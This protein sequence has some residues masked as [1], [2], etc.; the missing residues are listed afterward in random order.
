LAEEISTL[1]VVGVD[2]AIAVVADEQSAAELTE[3]SRRPGQPPRRVE[4]ALRCQSP[5][6]IARGVEN[7]DETVPGARNVMAPVAVLLSVGNVEEVADVLYVKW[8][9]AWR[10][11]R[12]LEGA[13][14][15]DRPEI[16]VEDVD[17]PA[18]EISSIEE[19]VAAR[20]GG[21]GESCVNSAAG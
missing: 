10:E 11:A 17:R 21:Q 4:H 20:I 9:K 6:E 12:I 13:L 2:A 1:R 5:D 7:I 15:D 19:V 8:S 18:A 16:L 14:A 3:F